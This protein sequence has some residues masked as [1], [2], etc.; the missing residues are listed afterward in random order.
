M[1]GPLE[2]VR[3]MRA[4]AP[5]AGQR[6][7][8][9]IR[10]RALRS[11]DPGFDR[12]LWRQMC[13]KG[14]L[15]ILVATDAGGSGAGMQAF[16]RVAE[17]LGAGL[18]PEPVTAAAMAALLL[19]RDRLADVLSGE[20]I[21]LPAWQE[22]PGGLALTGA[23]EHRDGRIDGR[24]LHVPMATGADAFLV[25]VPDG[26]ALVQR[27]APGLQIA[28][29]PTPDGGN[30]A[31][32][33]FDRTP[34][35]PIPGDA[36]DALDQAIVAH[37]AYLL[38]LITRAF[39]ITQ[40]TMKAREAFAQQSGF[41]WSQEARLEDM[42]RQVTLT[43]SVVRNAAATMDKEKRPA[44]RQSIASRAKL[45]ATDAA[46]LLTRTCVELH[47]GSGPATPPISYCSSARRSRWRPC[48]A[49]LRPTGCVAQRWHDRRR[50][51]SAP[52]ARH[53]HLPVRLRPD[54]DETVRRRPF[55]S[56]PGHGFGLDPRITRPRSP[57]DRVP[58]QCDPHRPGVQSGRPIAPYGEV[59]DADPYST[60]GG[61]SGAAIS[62]S[63]PSRTARKK[64]ERRPVW[65]ATPC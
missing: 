52:A 45:R 9:L 12:A 59:G 41:A 65:Q 55:S 39:A 49:R 37:A 60:S 11:T 61:T 2:H 48:T 28:T 21:V 42:Q 18:A 31:T 25:T 35:E 50:Q 10:V 51:N 1:V 54:L 38:G 44:A 33:L 47:I 30:F 3:M 19:P 27:D 34:A 6:N 57:D 4:N 5:G 43:R 36:A 32:L 14:W 8:D 29:Q 40:D 26:L 22:E 17:E 23:L 58:S 64:Q 13:G 16:C 24:K 63:T 46:L 7:A 53:C 20:R 15:G 62:T 56:R